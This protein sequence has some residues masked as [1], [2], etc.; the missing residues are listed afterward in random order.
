MIVEGEISVD[1][2]RDL[3]FRRM[4]DARFFASCIDGDFQCGYCTPGFVLMAKSL[5]ARRQCPSEQQIKTTF[6]G[7]VAL[8]GLSRDHRCGEMAARNSKTG[9][10][11]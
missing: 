6:P 4:S 2:P 7:T 11:G 3:V 9:A 1:A 5:L 10:S 8:R